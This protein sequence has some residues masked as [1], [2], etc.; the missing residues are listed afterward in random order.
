VITS[1]IAADRPR[2]RYLLGAA[3][4]LMAA[5]RTVGGDRAWDRLMAQQL[6]L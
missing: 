5:T 4:R 1:A 2:T 6:K 3:A